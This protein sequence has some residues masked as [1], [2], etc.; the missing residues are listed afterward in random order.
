MTSQ[1]EVD[2]LVI[3]AGPAGATV[4]AEAARAGARVMAV[5][6]RTGDSPS[7]AGVIQ[8]RVLE[9]LANRDLMGRFREAA[10]DW[11]PDFEVP[12]YMYAGLGGL[13]Y[14]ELDSDYPYALIL[15][16]TTTEHLLR[17]WA[18]EEGVD[19]RRGVTYVSHTQTDDGVLTELVDETGSPLT[20]RSS[21]LVGAD[22]ARSKVRAVAEVPFEGRD[23]TL[24][25]MSVDADLSFPWEASMRMSRN[26]AGWVLAYPFGVNT[27]RFIIV[28]EASRNL[29]TTVPVTIEE[30][31][32]SLT[33]IFGS[34]FGVTSAKRL[35]RYSDAHKMVP[36]L[37]DGRVLLVGEATRVHYPASGIGMNYCIQDA[38][39]LGW[40][41]GAAATGTAPD[42][43]LE[44]YH[45]E[46]FP[47][48]QAL[49]DDVDV[50][51]SLHFD[52]SEGGLKLKD[53]IERELVPLP[54]VNEILRNRLSGFGTSYRD[55]DE[56]HPAIGLRVPPITLAD[57]R[58]YAQLAAESSFVLLDGDPAI[59]TRQLPSA[60]SVAV[61]TGLA[62]VES[63][64]DAATVLIRPDGYVAF[65]WSAAPSDADIEREY[66]R[67]LHSQRT[68]DAAGVLV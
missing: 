1:I 34:D 40:K 42:E 58:R 60:I 68:L 49:M 45:E 12:I 64:G 43:L 25:A 22:G 21:Y 8:P 28:A 38:F 57:G 66:L 36:R 18:D 6:K 7:R 20:V 16:Q 59:P 11:R 27:T 35:S 61:A 3:G 46:R 33:D 62:S 17:A 54:G 5:E 39:N 9:Q 55:G 41:L 44:T 2:V 13:R 63:F 4:A 19:V 37:R 10:A 26:E 51:T 65:A 23:T 50:Q 15:P 56:P 67:A 29:D 31:Q 30:V 24:T 14:F 52:F 32:R 53:F 48:L 47:V